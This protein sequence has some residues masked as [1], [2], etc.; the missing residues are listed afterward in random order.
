[1]SLSELLAHYG[2]AFADGLITTLLLASVAWLVG[3]GGGIPL[4]VLAF[5]FPTTIGAM[6]RGVAFGLA[7]I[8]PI[9]LLYWAHY[10]L[11][12]F[13]N[14]VI[15]PF[16]T[17]SCVLSITNVVVVSEIIRSALAGFQH[18]YRIAAVVC[19]LT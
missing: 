14:I 5:R 1:M 11:Q 19:G 2:H 18:E 13:L 15:N 16:I 6:S 4:G 9:V 10:P 3:L 8:P 7:A 17:A 12:E